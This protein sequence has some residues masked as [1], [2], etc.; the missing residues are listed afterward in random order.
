MILVGPYDSPATRRVTIALHHDGLPF[1]RD[2]RLIFDDA[3]A[4]GQISPLTRIPALTQGP[5]K[6]SRLSSMKGISTPPN[7][8]VPIGSTVALV[9]PAPASIN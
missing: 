3:A 5:S 4:V 1:T 8:E 2:T 9:R 6:R 7:I